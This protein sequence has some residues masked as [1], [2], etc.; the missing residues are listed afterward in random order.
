MVERY[1]IPE[2]LEKRTFIRDGTIIRLMDD[3][4]VITGDT[5]VDCKRTL[6]GADVIQYNILFRN[7]PEGSRELEIRYDV[8]NSQVYSRY[9]GIVNKHHI[10]FEENPEWHEGGGQ[11]KKRSKRKRSKKR[12]KSKRSKKRTKRKRSKSKRSKRK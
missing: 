8:D 5:V 7:A 11:L 2:W 3:K 9:K 6:R 4:G 1:I 12:S 10:V